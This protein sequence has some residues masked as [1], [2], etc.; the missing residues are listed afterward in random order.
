MLE[1]GALRRGEIH[2]HT[3][4]LDKFFEESR[5]ERLNCIR[6]AAQEQ[7]N[8]V[9]LRNSFS[10]LW[11]GRKRFAFQDCHPLEAIRQ[12]ARRQE[13]GDARANDHSMSAGS[14]GDHGK[15]GSRRRGLNQASCRPGRR[16]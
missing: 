8:M 12:G 15:D 6:P 14:S 5:I 1:P 2:R 3:A 13:A 9:T 10:R 7:M 4:E 16:L 11:L